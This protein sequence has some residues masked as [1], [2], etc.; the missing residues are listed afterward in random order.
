MVSPLALRVKHEPLRSKAF[1]AITNAYTSVGTPVS[2]QARSILV[3]NL[4]DKTLFFSLNGVDDGWPM[5]Q[6]ASFIFDIT[7]NKTFD[8]GFY[9]AVGE[10]LYVKYTAALGQPTSGSVYL[11]VFYGD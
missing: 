4:T 5:M 6:G 3:Q 8:T 11:T 2:N 1:G 7:A 10:S 9:L